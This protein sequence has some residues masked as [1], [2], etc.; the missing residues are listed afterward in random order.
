MDVTFR[1]SEPFYGEKTDISMLF[2]ELDQQKNNEVGQEGE[3]SIVT[4]PEQHAPQPI[5]VSV[6]I[7]V[8]AGPSNVHVEPPIVQPENVQRWRDNILVYSRRPRQGVQQEQPVQ[9][10]NRCRGNNKCKGSN[11]RMMLMI[12]G[13]VAA[14][15]PKMGLQP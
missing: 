15:I 3:K 14:V 8:D 10:S 11:R 2:E 4:S 12:V 1:E 6:S 13:L 5:V 9:G 7:S